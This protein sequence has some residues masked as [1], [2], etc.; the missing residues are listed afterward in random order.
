[1]LSPVSSDR[2]SLLV[3]TRRAAFNRGTASPDYRSGALSPVWPPPVRL[4]VHRPESRLSWPLPDRVG[5]API[6]NP[7]ASL[8]ETVLRAPRL[9]AAASHGNPVRAAVESGAT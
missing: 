5:A 9:P 6:H 4:M 1:I 7:H 8:A 3:P 2:F